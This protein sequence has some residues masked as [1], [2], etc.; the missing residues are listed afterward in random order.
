M[1]ETTQDFEEFEAAFDDADYQDDTSDSAEEK[2]VTDHD[3]QEK[4]DEIGAGDE[5]TQENDDSDS[6]EPDSE[7]SEDAEKQ[8]EPE[9]F[10]LKVNKE[11]RTVS[12]DEMI[13]LAQKGSDYDRVKEQLAESKSEAAEIREKFEKYQPAI[14]VLDLLATSS[15][16]TIDQLA[17]QL[18]LNMLIKG[19]KTEAE[20]KAEIRAIKAESKL[21]A[22]TAKETAKK[23]AAEESKARADREV[24]E[25]KKRFPNVEL[26]E[27]L[28]KELMPDVQ[29]GIPL[30]EAYQKRELAKKD[31]ELAEVRRK[32]EAEQ[33]NKKN[34][35]T[36][37][38]SQRDSGGRREKSDF[39]DFMSAYE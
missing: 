11:E 7:K 17:E 3:I 34:R 14:D 23:S 15:G 22:V 24:A 16:Q 12:R 20:A 31:A 30:S 2:E 33:Q 38:G 37:T 4:E 6:Q 19:G 5:E 18:H 8:T 9:T 21:N 26:T 35:S 36:T 32:L 28:C 27:E 1:D 29:A 10:T 13:A 39:D 25:F